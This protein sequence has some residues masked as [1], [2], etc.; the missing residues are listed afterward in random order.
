VSDGSK[1][2][3]SRVRAIDEI[4]SKDPT[5]LTASINTALEVLA[6]SQ[7]ERFYFCSKK[8]RFGKGNDE[9]WVPLELVQPEMA[10]A[11]LEKHNIERS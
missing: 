7:D 1:C 4:K 11:A 5:F 8:S 2:P 9:G 6:L 3:I 10:S